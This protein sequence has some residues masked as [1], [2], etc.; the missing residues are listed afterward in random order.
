MVVPYRKKSHLAW[1]RWLMAQPSSLDHEGGFPTCVA[2][3]HDHSPDPHRLHTFRKQVYTGLLLLVCRTH[4]L[5]QDWFFQLKSLSLI[6][7]SFCFLRNLESIPPTTILDRVAA[8]E[9]GAPFHSY[10]QKAFACR[11]GSPKFFPFSGKQASLVLVTS[12]FLTAWA[13]PLGSPVANLSDKISC[14]MN[15]HLGTLPYTAISDN[16]ISNSRPCSSNRIHT[17][18]T[19]SQTTE[20]AFCRLYM[21]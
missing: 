13:N 10:F 14:K 18:T 8:T 7:N 17:F 16:R 12:A 11:E 1:P 20:C 5:L 21:R 3:I 4:N 9:T 19:G 15:D 6:A 2:S